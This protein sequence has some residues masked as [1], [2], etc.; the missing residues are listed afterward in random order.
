MSTVELK[1]KCTTYRLTQ[2]EYFCHKTF[3]Q[4]GSAVPIIGSGVAA[5]GF[6]HVVNRVSASAFTNLAGTPGGTFEAMVWVCLYHGLTAFVLGATSGRLRGYIN[7]SNMFASYYLRDGFISLRNFALSFLAGTFF[8]IAGVLLLSF[9]VSEDALLGAQPGFAPN[10]KWFEAFMAEFL[11]SVVL[12]SIV[13][14]YAGNVNNALVNGIALAVAMT[15]AYE[16]TGASLNPHRYNAS[17]IA[18]YIL[19]NA[20]F[21]PEEFLV[22]NIAPTLAAF[23]VAFLVKIGIRP[24]KIKNKS[25]KKEGL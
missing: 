24:A 10:V 22:Y 19:G 20:R 5:L 15:V 17:L 16:T 18:N 1:G 6:H 2:V 13:Y 8:A 12:F 14:L 7:P 21:E 9:F 23:L 11:A 3:A 25:E 4:F